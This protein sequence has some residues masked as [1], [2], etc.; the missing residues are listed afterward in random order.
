MTAQR[1]VYLT[2]SLMPLLGIALTGFARVSFVL[3][4]PVAMLGFAGITGVC[5]G[6]LFWRR[7]GLK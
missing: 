6:L 3:Y 2:A 4:I 7:C 5:P 1:M